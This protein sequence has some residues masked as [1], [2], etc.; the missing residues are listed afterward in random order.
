MLAMAVGDAADEGGDDDLGTLAANG[1]NGVVEDAI[2]TPLLECFFL[3]FRESEV[4]FGSPELLC[5]VVLVGLEEFVGAEDAEGVVGFGGHGVLAA[6]AA[7]QGEEHGADAEA[8]GEIGEQG[9]IFVVRV[10]DDHHDAG[11]GIEL[12]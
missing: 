11:G 9:A 5:A 7:R 2:V 10:G 3:R 8:A 1:E 4:D 6:F 12:L